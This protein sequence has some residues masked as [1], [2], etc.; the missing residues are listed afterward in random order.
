VL[1]VQGKY[2]QAGEM[3]RQALGL[4]ETVLGKERPSTLMSMSNLAN[5]L[6]NQGKRKEAEEMH[7]QALRLRETVLICFFVCMC[8]ILE[9][10]VTR[11]EERRRTQHHSSGEAR[12]VL[13]LLLRIDTIDFGTKGGIDFEWNR[14]VRQK[15]KTEAWTPS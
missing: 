3:H 5:V 6:S 15:K 11:A 10:E 7:R 12:L 2:E 8:M 13:L 9:Q 4:S 1:G 14:V